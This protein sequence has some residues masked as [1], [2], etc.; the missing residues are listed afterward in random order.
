MSRIVSLG[1]FTVLSSLMCAMECEE[2]GVDFLISITGKFLKLLF[3]NVF[4]VG[5]NK[6]SSLRVFYCDC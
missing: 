6:S 2:G 5:I 3:H 1:T 4:E